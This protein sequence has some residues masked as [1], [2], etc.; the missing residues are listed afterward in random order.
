MSRNLCR[1][2]ARPTLNAFDLCTCFAATR[3]TIQAS[4]SGTCLLFPAVQCQAAFCTPYNSVKKNRTTRQAC[5]QSKPVPHCLCMNYEQV[6]RGR[7]QTVCTH[8]SSEN[9]TEFHFYRHEV[10]KE[11]IFVCVCVYACVRVRMCVCGCVWSVN[12][13]NN[14]VCLYRLLG[15]HA[16]LHSTGL[17]EK[18]CK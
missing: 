17:A 11:C 3:V 5:L 7:P 12:C 14:W 6:Q 2:G 8:I 13:P 9:G 15:C 18:L 1:Y 4:F 16:D 10:E